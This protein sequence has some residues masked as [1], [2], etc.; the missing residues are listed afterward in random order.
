MPYGLT[1]KGTQ[2]P[3]QQVFFYLI[4]VI[5]AISTLR[6]FLRKR[7]ILHY[8]A[9][10]VE[11]KLKAKENIVLLDVRTA[12]ER[13]RR[14]IPGSSHIPLHELKERMPEIEKFKGREI[15]CYCQSGN[16]SLS[17]ALTLKRHGFRVANLS[18]GMASWM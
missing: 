12:G 13:S 18:G 11:A 16:R 6:M 10:E 9:G 17:A 15:I 5:I 2:M 14:H 7:S 4:I 1:Y 8:R 3:A